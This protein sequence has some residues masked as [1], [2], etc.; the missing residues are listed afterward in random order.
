MLAARLGSVTGWSASLRHKDSFIS[1][2]LS[3]R[4]RP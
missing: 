3:E 2:G 4:G 1:Q